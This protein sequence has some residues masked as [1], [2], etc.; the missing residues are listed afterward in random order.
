MIPT[1]KKR[2]AGEFKSMGLVHTLIHSISVFESYELTNG[3]H[4]D[5]Y[6]NFRKTNSGLLFLGSYYTKN[7]ALQS[8]KVDSSMFDK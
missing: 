4:I 2:P 1:R 5:G 7:K 3:S 8:L 6:T